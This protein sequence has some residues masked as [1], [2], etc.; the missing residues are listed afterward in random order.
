MCLQ[1]NPWPHKGYID[2]LS[3]RTDYLQ[4]VLHH[5]AIQDRRISPSYIQQQHKYL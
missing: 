2:Y 4:S 3:F 5:F 1:D